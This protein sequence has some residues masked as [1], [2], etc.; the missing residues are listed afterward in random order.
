[1]LNATRQYLSGRIIDDTIAHMPSY[2]P[3]TVRLSDEDAEELRQIHEKVTGE[4]LSLDE[5]KLMGQDLVWFGRFYQELVSKH[6]RDKDKGNS[7][8]SISK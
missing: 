4:K 3:I 7:E 1:M 8:T 2:M 5:A 6:K